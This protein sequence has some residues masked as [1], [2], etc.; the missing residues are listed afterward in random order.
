MYKS[1]CVDVIDDTYMC[2]CTSQVYASSHVYSFTSAR[3]LGGRWQ[4]TGFLHE[5]RPSECSGSTHATQG[6]EHPCQPTTLSPKT[7]AYIPPPSLTLDTAG[8]DVTQTF[9]SQ[10]LKKCLRGKSRATLARSVTPGT[11]GKAE[12]YPFWTLIRTV[13]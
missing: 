2:V 7:F 13:T 5:S 3:I 4:R 12:A 8:R 10:S 9:S 1:S 11:R 6:S